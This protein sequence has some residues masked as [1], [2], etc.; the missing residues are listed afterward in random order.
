MT[1]DESGYFVC[2][3]WWENTDTQA[4]MCLGPVEGEPIETKDIL[5]KAAEI[6]TGRVDGP[7]RKGVAGFDAW[8][9]MLSDDSAFSGENESLLFERMLCEDDA[10]TCLIDGR[11]CAAEYFKR[12][13]EKEAVSDGADAE[14]KNAENYKLLSDLFAKEK[15][16]AEQTWSLL[17]GWDN[18]EQRPAKLA[19]KSVREQACEYIKQIEVLE[20]RCL[21]V[22]K[23]LGE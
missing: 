12:L 17:G 21:G 6:M 2:D 5:K 1:F 14:T 7:Y 11:G 20:E 15:T 16:L 13:V 8:A 3:N 9:K 23:E 10:T 22:L 4:V 19:E 18:M